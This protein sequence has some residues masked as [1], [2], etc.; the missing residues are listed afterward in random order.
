M[1][2]ITTLATHGIKCVPVTVEADVA[3]GLNAFNIVGLPDASVKESR[4]RIR[5]AIKNS[6]FTFPRGRITVNL[7]P[8]DV[9]K[10]GPIYDLPIALS[11]LVATGDISRSAIEQATFVGELALDG[12]IRSVQG[13]LLAAIMT[14]EIGKNTLFVPI[15]NTNEA[16]AIDSITVYG[17][18]SLRE[19]VE[20]DRKSVV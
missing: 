1:F 2:H 4:D 19:T 7:A 12:S 20:Q 8:A 17:A 15:C 11:I 13:T 16:S 10:Q 9:R 18:S 6:G 3:F 5:A 14:K